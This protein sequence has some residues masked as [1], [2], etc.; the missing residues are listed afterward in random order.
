MQAKLHLAFLFILIGFA[1][2]MT[3]QIV[4]AEP[5]TETNLQNKEENRCESVDL[6]Y[7][8]ENGRILDTC[9]EKDTA[10]LTIQVESD[11]DD[12]LVID[13]P[14]RLV[15]SFENLDCKEGQM[16][17]VLDGEVIEP[18][19]ISSKTKNTITVDLQKG[20]HQIEFIG[21]FP[22][23]N[24]SPA[25]Y[26][27]IVMGYDTQYLPPKLQLKLG[28]EPEQVRC[29]QGLELAIK[30]SDGNPIC[31]TPSTKSKLVERNW[32]KEAQ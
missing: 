1:V 20:T 9:Y 12:H 31:V 19:M 3:T 14:K 5:Q 18:S 15:Y 16:I 26:C 25:M 27:G 11:S 32:A 13:I 4:F 8:I 22:V 29:N 6:N 23:P 24:P 2:L 30:T 17:I 7:T 21:T 10:T 28:V